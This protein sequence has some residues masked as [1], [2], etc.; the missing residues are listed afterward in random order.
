MTEKNFLGLDFVKT[1]V[2]VNIFRKKISFSQ[3]E[4]VGGVNGKCI[5]D[6]EKNL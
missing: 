5:Y 1:G 3:Y 6:F 2:K 4:L